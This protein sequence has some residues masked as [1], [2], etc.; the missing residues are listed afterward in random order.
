MP[1]YGFSEW[2]DET[3]EVIGVTPDLTLLIDRDKWL[4]AHYQEAPPPRRISPWL[5]ALSLGG[6]AMGLMLVRE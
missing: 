6:I 1:R 3:E 2:T 5:L 4:T